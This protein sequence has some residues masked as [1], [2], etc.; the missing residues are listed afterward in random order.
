MAPQPETRVLACP[1]MRRLL[2]KFTSAVS[3]HERMQ[4]AQLVAV[5]NGDGTLFEEWIAKAAEQKDQAKQAIITH[6]Q[7]HGC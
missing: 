6:R 4:T 1:E 2:Q 3:E 7:E 5:M